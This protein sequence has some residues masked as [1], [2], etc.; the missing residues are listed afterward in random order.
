VLAI[1]RG[2]V[3][4]GAVLARVLGAELDVVL[5]RKLRAP[6]QPELAIGGLGEDGHIYLNHQAA[7]VPGLTAQYLAR[8]RRCQLAEIARRQKLFRAVRPAAPFTGRSVIL[9]DDGIATGS[10]MLGALHV[11]T[12]QHPDEVIV[13]VPVAPPERLAELR[14]QC[15]EVVCLLT[16]AG[17]WAVGRFYAD[18]PQVEDT[19]VVELLQASL[20]APHSA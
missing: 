1:P 20:P 3:V 5:A 11:F 14:R 2:G 4:I 13:A 17:F 18:F 8:E 7:G 19:E 16:P 10:T 9:T 12:A 6:G 15:D